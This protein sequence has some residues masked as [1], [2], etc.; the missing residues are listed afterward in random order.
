VLEGDW[1]P[2]RMGII[3]FPD[4]AALMAWYRLPEYQPL[5][6]VRKAAAEDVL[7][8]VESK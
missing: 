6:A 2:D 4:K 1:R 8:V 3:E 5:I 7:I